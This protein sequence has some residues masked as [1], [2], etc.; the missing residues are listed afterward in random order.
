[1]DIGIGAL[2]P[3]P[4]GEIFNLRDTLIFSGSYIASYFAWAVTVL[5]YGCNFHG[6]GLRI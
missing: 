2:A 1:M 3:L 6:R 4:T 5:L